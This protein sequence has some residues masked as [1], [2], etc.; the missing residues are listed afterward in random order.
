MNRKTHLNKIAALLKDGKRF[1]LATH[2]DP[3]G[4]GLGS[5]LALGQALLN[6]HKEVVFVTEAPVPPP[7]DLLQGAENI[8]Q[9]FEP[10]KRFDGVLVLDCGDK[11]RLGGLQRLIEERRPLINIDHHE[12]NDFFG[13]LNL[14]ET[15]VSSTAEM[16][17]ALIRSAGLPMSHAVAENLFVAIQTDTGSFR[18][19]NTTSKCLRIAAEMLDFGVKPW[20]VSRRVMDSYS[21]SRLTLLRMALGAM[22]FHHHGKIGVMTISSE[23]FEKSNARQEDSEKF[24]DYPRYVNGV[25][26]AVLIRQTGVD[27]YK[28]S[29]RSN[30]H[31]NVARLA[32]KFGGG[33]HARAAGFEAHGSIGDLKTH[34][35]EEAARL[36]DGSNN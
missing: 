14:V 3:D 34:F 28:F 1:L 2:K 9:E 15:K 30:N 10:S 29:L 4:D 6:A 19:E 13:D 31:A 7:F 36:L 26:I 16:V 23:L 18:Y 22:E 25:E 5:M 35:L 17:L 11:E 32:L 21:V 20:E 8:V 12:T 27:E 24:V 33:G